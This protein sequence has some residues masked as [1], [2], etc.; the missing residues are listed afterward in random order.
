M[1]IVK[2]KKAT[3]RA[4]NANQFSPMLILC[5]S[6]KYNLAKS[7]FK[8]CEVQNYSSKELF[9]NRNGT[10]AEKELCRSILYTLN[11]R[12]HGT[13]HVTIVKKHK[14]SLVSAVVSVDHYEHIFQ[15][16]S[17][18]D[19]RI[20]DDFH[21]IL[22]SLRYIDE[23]IYYNDVITESID[24]Y[25]K[26]MTK[27]FPNERKVFMRKLKSVIAPVDELDSLIAYTY[28]KMHKALGPKA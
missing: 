23:T 15:F 11:V 8:D 14:K 21:R 4:N 17:F 3:A 12:A 1:A 16:D 9:H 7:L 22:A 26:K 18:D 28:E 13:E 5:S 2:A 27:L 10:D 25:R 6:E 24:T 20:Y 19:V